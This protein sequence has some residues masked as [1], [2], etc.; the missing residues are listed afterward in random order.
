MEMQFGFA[1][2]FMSYQT[3]YFEPV[4][5]DSLSSQANGSEPTT[6]Q[7]PVIR[8]PVESSMMMDFMNHA[9][10]MVSR[11]MGMMAGSGMMANPFDTDTD[12]S[13]AN[14][15][16]MGGLTTSSFAQPMRFNSTFIQ[17]SLQ[18]FGY[19][20][21]TSSSEQPSRPAPLTEEPVFVAETPAPVA[22]QPVPDSESPVP[23]IDQVMPQ[24][25]VVDELPPLDTPAAA[26]VSG[27]ESVADAKP[28]GPRFPIAEV[29]AEDFKR[30]RLRQLSTQLE[31]SL[32][33]E[34]K[35][36]DGDVITLDFSQLDIVEATR[37]RGRTHDGERYRVNSYYESTKR[38]VNVEVRGELSNAEKEAINKVLSAVI[39]AADKFFDGSLDKAM[40]QLMSMDFDTEELAEFSLRMN[41]S[42][43]V[44]VTR[45]YQG[46]R[47][48]LAHLADRDNGIMKVLKHFARE[49][50]K[51]IDLASEVLNK[52]SAVRLVK[53]LL[54]P[55]L[56]DPLTALVNNVQN[57]KMAAESDAQIQNDSASETDDDDETHHH[58]HH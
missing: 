46:G 43:S 28:H 44:E 16:S 39:E 22:E 56:E 14:G 34:L 45:A 11:Q 18:V 50:H 35:T 6:S 26:L 36:Q 49:Q 12:G 37:F 20:M 2:G 42:K 40:K 52:E 25:P 57:H 10:L 9:Y 21:P 30:Y 33:L 38:V 32:K 51:L 13:S 15:E 17:F 1:A 4:Q 27:E 19:A 31:T 8:E 58:H 47:R 48:N 55:M 3:S 7:L 24:V 5:A 53:T 41:M 29:S 23:V 54:P